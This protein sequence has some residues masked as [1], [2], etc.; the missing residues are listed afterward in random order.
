V[1]PSPESI[2]AQ[3]AP[4]EPARPPGV[5]A[6]GPDLTALL[7]EL[8]A[9]SAALAAAAGR[10][11]EARTLALLELE[12]YDRRVAQQQE[13]EAVGA[14][15]RQVQ[16][17]AAVLADGAYTD[18]A[19]AAAERVARVAAASA[20]AAVGVAEGH[21]RE[22]ERLAAA[23]DLARLLDERRRQ[24]EAERARTAAAE[25]AGRAAG[26]RAAVSEALAAGRLED[27][28]T[29]AR[30]AVAEFPDD[31]GLAA[32]AE[33]AVRRAALAT[34]A[35]AEQSVLEALR[36]GRRNPGAAVARL[37]ALDVEGLPE[38]VARRAFGAWAR[39][40]ARLCQQRG[41]GGALRY[42]PDTGRGAVLTPERPDGPYVVLSAIGMGPDWAAHA[43][44][45]ERFV[46]RARPLR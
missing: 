40:C 41:I 8:E 31:A 34:T 30:D 13:A 21:R 27:A 37:E 35:A 39:A 29:R 11:R 6:E 2:L 32:L 1:P 25:R 14:R 17:A 15:A 26:V 23:L 12:Q 18:A 45:D 28:R 24:E 20:A 19:R 22:A 3:A 5:L 7:A 38:A 42:A 43:T 36:E 44:I 10:D 46:R 9:A 4:G 16:E 33:A